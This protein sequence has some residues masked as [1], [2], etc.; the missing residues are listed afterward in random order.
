[1]V[2]PAN[3]KDADSIFM[4]STKLATSFELTREAFDRSFADLIQLPYMFLRVYELQ[5][6]II[7]Y[8]LGGYHPCFYASGNTAWVDEIYVGKNQRRSG[9]GRALV[10]SFESWAIQH[11][12]QVSS[13]ATRRASDFYLSLGYANS[14]NYFKKHL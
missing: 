1:M 4:L 12:C 5:G 8:I 7:G 10:D 11:G 6:E 9:V 2:R 14:A 13:L 3:R